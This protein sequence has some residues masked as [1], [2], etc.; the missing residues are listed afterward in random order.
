MNTL[1]GLVETE[2]SNLIVVSI[3]AMIVVSIA[4]MTV[5]LA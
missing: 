1:I 2:D 3:A 5:H 4:A